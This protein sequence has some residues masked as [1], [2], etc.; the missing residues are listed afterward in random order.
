MCP[1]HRLLGKDLYHLNQRQPTSE[2]N[3]LIINRISARATRQR[4]WQIARF[5]IVA[6]RSRTVLGRAWRNQGTRRLNSVSTNLFRKPSRCTVDRR[7]T[8]TPAGTPIDAEPQDL[9][10]SPGR[11]PRFGEAARVWRTLLM[12]AA[13]SPSGNLAL[14][15]RF[16]PL[17]AEGLA[18]HGCR[19]IR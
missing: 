8:P 5:T 9:R 12:D 7:K 13:S 15:E 2:V 10:T 19:G 14:R 6:S 18:H 3:N 11:L 17:A 4:T 16:P 1:R